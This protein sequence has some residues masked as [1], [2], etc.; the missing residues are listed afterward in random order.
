MSHEPPNP[1][2]EAKEQLIAEL[3]DE[4]SLLKDQLKIAK[5]RI[6]Y[7]E[8]RRSNDVNPWYIDGR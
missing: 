5:E 2:E 3:H 7:L 1:F 6:E 8:E 4:I